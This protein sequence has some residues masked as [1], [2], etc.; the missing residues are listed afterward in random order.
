MGVYPFCKTYKQFKIHVSQRLNT[1]EAD[2]ANEARVNSE[3]FVQ[4]FQPAAI[5]KFGITADY[6]VR[7]PFYQEERYEA[8]IQHEGVTIGWP[9]VNQN[10]YNRRLYAQTVCF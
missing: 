1:Y 4:R 2:V 9:R 8:V 6:E 7:F 10:L 5:Y 3:N